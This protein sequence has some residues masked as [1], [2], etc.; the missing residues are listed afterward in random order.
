MNSI[1]IETNIAFPF[2]S[3]STEGITVKADGKV[4][5]V[6][7]VTSNE[8]IDGTTTVAKIELSE[9]VKLKSKTYDLKVRFSGKGSGA[10]RCN[11]KC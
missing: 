9:N 5:K 2:I 7:K 1:S 3:E 11:E 8:V 10:W 6:K 4:L